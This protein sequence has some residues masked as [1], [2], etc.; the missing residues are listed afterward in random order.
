M[1]KAFKELDKLER[2]NFVA[3]LLKKDQKQT[4]QKSMGK[5]V[6]NQ[7]T[8]AAISFDEYKAMIPAMRKQSRQAYLKQRD[9]QVLDLYKRN[10]DEE[11]RIFQD[12]DL[13]PEEKRIAELKKTLFNLAQKFRQKTDTEDGYRFPGQADEDEEEGLTREQKIFNKMN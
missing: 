11:S 8:G 2:D 5:I 4:E 10:L 6:E 12:E 1:K 7:D 3:D 13:T 9:E